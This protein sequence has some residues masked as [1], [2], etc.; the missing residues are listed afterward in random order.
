[1]LMHRVIHTGIKPH[2]CPFC[3]E[4]FIRKAQLRKHVEET[5]PDQQL[6][7]RPA[8]YVDREKQRLEREA[9]KAQGK[10]LA[11][12]Q[13]AAAAA[14]T[15]AAAAKMFVANQQTEPSASQPEVETKS[16]HNVVEAVLTAATAERAVTAVPPPFL[17]E[18]PDLNQSAYTTGQFP[19]AASMLQQFSAANSAS[20]LHVNTTEGLLSRLN[21]LQNNQ[22]FSQH[23]YYPL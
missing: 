17:P 4:G 21:E 16:E 8:F 3:S 10:L 12:Q 9:L 5:H 1:M 15:N 18:V 20:M 23:N 7:N 14:A 2:P 6:P 22:A 13:A 19:A 11:E